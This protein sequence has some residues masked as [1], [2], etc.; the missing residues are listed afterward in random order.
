MR[1]SEA[2]MT[3]DELARQQARANYLRQQQSQ[4]DVLRKSAMTPESLAEAIRLSGYDPQGKEQMLATMLRGGQ[5][6]LFG[7]MPQGK[8]VGE[9]YVAP[10]WSETL[11]AAVQKGLGGYQMGQARNEQTSIDDQRAAA[12]S[13]EA[14]VA[15][16]QARAKQLADA[17]EAIMSTMDSQ[18]D[19]DRAERKMAQAAELAGLAR[20]AADA[21]AAKSDSGGEKRKL[22]TFHDPADPSKPLNLNYDASGNF[23]DMEGNQMPGSFIS[24][25]TPY[26]APSSGSVGRG[27]AP[28]AS[29]QEKNDAL[30]L[31]KDQATMTILDP[32]LATATG[33]PLDPERWA[34]QFG[35]PG[36]EDA[37]ATGT[38]AQAVTMAAVAPT[39]DKLGVNPTDRDLREA[40]KTSPGL[41]TQ[42]ETWV[43]WYENTYMP[44]MS[45][46][47][48]RDNP[49]MHDAVMAEMAAA[50][51]KAKE[52]QKRKPESET[53]NTS[54]W[55][56]AR[57]VE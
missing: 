49:T 40:F 54:G 45:S 7:E 26:K 57:V 31:E 10:T 23:Y 41:G 19:D 21:R 52:V 51:V 12:S 30:L 55:S 28:K 1:S 29:P 14:Q 35:L 37:Q 5:D 20:A 36:Y 33:H 6:A 39:L 9:V 47:L 38:R 43:D 22:K 16:E 13:A 56:G 3:P 34:S 48:N 24:S 11:N 4:A 46:A 53:T 25:L 8:R 42:P 50:V 32:N 18:S 17:E 27:S 44:A 15:A 2:A